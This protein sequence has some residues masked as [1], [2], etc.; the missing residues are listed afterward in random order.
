MKSFTEINIGSANEFIGMIHVAR[1]TIE[2][3]RTVWP[4]LNL[5]FE[6]TW[7]GPWQSVFRLRS[8]F[9][10]FSVALRICI[11]TLGTLVVTLG[12][13]VVTL[14]TLVVLREVLVGRC[15]WSG[16]LGSLL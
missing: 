7:A 14:R 6:I 3:V 5:R 1:S 11:L 16:S 9:K 13:L 8:I 15:G 10:G 12:N 2:E 4:S